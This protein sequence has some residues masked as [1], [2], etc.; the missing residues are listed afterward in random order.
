MDRPS[1]SS[2]KVSVRDSNFQDRIRLMLHDVESDSDIESPVDDSDEDPH[3]VPANNSQE[4]D[5]E[6]S[7]DDDEV[8][9]EDLQELNENE[10]MNVDEPN[11][12]EYLFSRLKKGEFGPPYCWTTKEPPRNVRTPARNII[13]GRLPGLLQPAKALGN[14]PSTK[15]VWSLLFDDGMIQ[16]IVTYTN[17]KLESVRSGLDERTHKS[18]YRNT[19]ELEI[20]A[21]IGLQLLASIL[22]S[23]REDMASLFSKDVTNRPYFNATMSVK[24]FEILTSCIRFDDK[25]TRVQRKKENKAAAISELFSQFISNSQENYSV[26]SCVTVDEMLVPFRGRCSFRVY[27]PKKP[28]KYGIK[29]QCLCDAA[30]SYLYNGYIYTGKDSDGVG[31]TEEELMLQKPTQTVVRLSKPLHRT[32]RNITCDNYFTSLETVDVLR[33]KG[34]TVVGTLNKNRLVIPQEHLPQSGRPV[35]SS[36]HCFNNGITMVSYVP[37]KNKAVILMSSMHYTS[38]IDE[39]THKPEIICYYNKTKCGVDLM[40]MKCAIYASNRRTRRWPHALFCRILNVCGVNAYILY[41]CYKDA[42]IVSR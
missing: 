2:G 18:N 19:D 32:N 24:R 28:H 8:V 42:P 27:M 30:T 35:G 13:R 17:K 25:E 37:K 7:D 34:L 3:Y 23:S 20:N 36:L 5:S 41:L 38:D 10:E 31:L 29:V 1:T 40:D 9:D 11:R 22:K 26:S 16:N 21:Y 15:D 14:S 33:S 6:S 4:N 12:P 39:K